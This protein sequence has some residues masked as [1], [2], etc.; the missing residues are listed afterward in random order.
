ML[1]APL[2]VISP[3]LKSMR[4]HNI[5]NTCDLELM[6]HTVL[7]HGVFQ[8]RIRGLGHD[9]DCRCLHSRIDVYSHSDSILI[10]TELCIT[11]WTLTWD[12]T[13]QSTETL[14][15]WFDKILCY[16]FNAVSFYILGSRYTP[17]LIWFRAAVGN[18]KNVESFW[19][20]KACEWCY[21]DH[22]SKL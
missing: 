4:V 1:V 11:I 17:Q 15:I 22:G 7:N 10:L 12:V 19:L 18:K 13:L 2:V 14:P 3:E 9:P 5:W 21:G 6:I 20:C 16:R 8:Y